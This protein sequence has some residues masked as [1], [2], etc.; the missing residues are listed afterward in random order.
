VPADVEVECS[1][2]PPP[3]TPSAADACDPAPSIAFEESRTDG[4]CA[5]EWTLERLWTASDDCGNVATATQV[6]TVR[7]RTPPHVVPSSEVLRVLWPPSHRTICLGRDAA[8]PVVSDACGSDVA[9]RWAECLS[10][11]PA[12][13]AGDGNT[14]E[15]CTIE[16][17]GERVC[18]R[19]ERQGGDHGGRS[20]SLAI[21]ATDECGNE[22]GSTVIGVVLVPHD[23][24]R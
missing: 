13:G 3:A 2:V 22:S 19:A 18:V 20:Y 5:N 12:N 8:S 4:A 16:D 14:A 23:R 17:D 1:D 15:D 6:V 11:Q 10:D 9:W 21:V 24:R 7:D